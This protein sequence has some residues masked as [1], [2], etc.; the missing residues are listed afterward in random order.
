MQGRTDKMIRWLYADRMPVTKGLIVINIATFLV[1]TLFRA[2]AVIA[3]LGFSSMMAAA[4]P[5]TAITYPLLGV[6]GSVINLFFAGYWLW[7]AGG[8]L[9]RSWGSRTFGIFFFSASALSALGLYLGSS[10]TGIPTSAVGLWLPL[11][12]LTV[13]FAMLNP[14]QTILFAFII[15]L[16]LK[17]LAVISAAMVLISFGQAHILLGLFSLAGCSYAYWYV[18]RGARPVHQRRKLQYE[19]SGRVIRIRDKHSIWR[20]LS[21]AARYRDYRDRKRLKDFFNR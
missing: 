6:S 13:A 17:Y 11:A 5:W 18:R 14:E 1:V 12:A 15:P 8:S 10:I 9:E 7:F 20:S 3:L 19:D 2:E 4:M 16:K 21:P